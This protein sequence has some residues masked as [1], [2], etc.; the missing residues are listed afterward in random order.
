MYYKDLTKYEYDKTQ[1]KW[2]RKVNIGWLDLTKDYPKGKTSKLFSYCLFVICIFHINAMMGYHPCSFCETKP[3]ALGTRE[4][5]FGVE[6]IFGSAEIR[7][8]GIN[9]AIYASP[10]LIYHYVTKHH[11]KP[12]F[13][14]VLSTIISGFFYFPFFLLWCIIFYIPHIL[15]TPKRVPGLYKGGKLIKPISKIKDDE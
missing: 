3:S 10:N 4:R 7:L 12:P 13:L 8:I 14:F 5:L 6:A 11:Y 15:F 9:G 2:L 1:I